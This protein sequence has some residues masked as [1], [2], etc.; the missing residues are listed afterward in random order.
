MACDKTKFG[1]SKT[2]IQFYF[3][4]FVRNLLQD[5]IRAHIFFPVRV[6]SS[7]NLRNFEMQILPSGTCFWW[8]YSAILSYRVFLDRCTGER[9]TSPPTPTFTL[10]RR[11][12]T[13]CSKAQVRVFPSFA[14]LPMSVHLRYSARANRIKMKDLRATFCRCERREVNTDYFST[15]WHLGRE[16]SSKSWFAKTL[17]YLLGKVS[18]FTH[19]EHWG[20]FRAAEILDENWCEKQLQDAKISEDFFSAE[21]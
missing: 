17:L 11:P 3:S 5:V 21:T 4:S 9:S 14:S 16:M 13:K 15:V 18:G 7:L 2:L 1:V 12:S 10:I 6:L 19:T 20:N 8:N